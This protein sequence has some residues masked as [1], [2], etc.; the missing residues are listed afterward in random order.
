MDD[1]IRIPYWPEE[2]AKKAYSDGYFIEAIQVVHG[3][4]ELQLR[5]LLF[6]QRKVPGPHEHFDLAVDTMYEIPLSLA[7]KILFIQKALSKEERD[8]LIHFNKTRNNIVH[9]IYYDTAHEGYSGY[10]RKEFDKA[11]LAGL[12][13]MTLLSDRIHRF[14]EQ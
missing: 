12:E 11:Y 7:V 1:Y 5:E 6:L 4:I 10:P 3:F 2:H 8:K 13:L 14:M 9:K